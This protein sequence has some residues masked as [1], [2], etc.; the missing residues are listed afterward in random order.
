MDQD[1]KHQAEDEIHELDTEF[2][3]TFITQKE[4]D[5]SSLER[6]EVPPYEI[7]DFRREYQLI[8]LDA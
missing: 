3:T 5:H 8:F 6:G 4:H 1:G 2:A 7:D